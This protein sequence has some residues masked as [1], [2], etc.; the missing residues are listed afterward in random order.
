MVDQNKRESSHGDSS[1]KETGFESEFVV[2][3]SLPRLLNARSDESSQ[4]ILE[5]SK[6][7]KEWGPPW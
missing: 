5:N 3:D 6:K 4:N 1:P 7:T 2:L